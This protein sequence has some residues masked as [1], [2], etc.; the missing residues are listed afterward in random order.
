MGLCLVLWATVSTTA[1]GVQQ[2]RRI[3]GWSGA[4]RVFAPGARPA[5]A[6]RPVQR[7]SRTLPPRHGFR[8][9]VQDTVGSVG[10]DTS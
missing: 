7:C 10:L 4:G 3:P 2:A 1:S 8:T 6:R 5:A 9:R